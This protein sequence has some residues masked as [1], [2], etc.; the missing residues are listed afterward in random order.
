MDFNKYVQDRI[1]AASR[2][3]LHSCLQDLQILQTK[4]FLKISKRHSAPSWE[5]F[6][7]GIGQCAGSLMTREPRNKSKT[8]H[9]HAVV[10]II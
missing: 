8:S 5:V 6:L 4:L 3:L 10:E 2:L 1:R 7:N 9:K